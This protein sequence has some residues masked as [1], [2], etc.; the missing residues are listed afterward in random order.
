MKKT[1]ISPEYNVEVEMNDIILVSNQQEGDSY[2]GIVDIEE[3]FG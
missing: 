1:Y 2:I 3:I